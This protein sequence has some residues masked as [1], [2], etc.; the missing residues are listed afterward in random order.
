MNSVGG[1][2]RS[3]MGY[4][5]VVDIGKRSWWLTEPTDGTYVLEP[6]LDMPVMACRFDNR[7]DAEELAGLEGLSV[8]CVVEIES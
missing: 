2:G 1:E 5:I 4:C 8:S 7:A 6:G 3:V